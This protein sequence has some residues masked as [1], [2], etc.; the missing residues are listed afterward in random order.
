MNTATSPTELVSAHGDVPTKALWVFFVAQIGFGAIASATT[1]AVALVPILSFI[2]FAAVLMPRV[3]IWLL[4]VS[5]FLRVDIPGLVGVYPGDIVALLL[6][7]GLAMHV[8]THGFRR[9]SE[10]P[11][12]A[13][14]TAMMV[15]FAISLLA[16]FDPALGLKNWFRHLQMTFVILAASLVLD[17]TD[18]R[19]VLMLVLWLS[20]ALS[21]PNIIEAI[22]LGSSQRV[23][24]ISSLF[25]PFYLATAIIYCTIAYLLSESRWKRIL[26]LIAAI[27]LG[28]GIIATQT[29]EAMLHTV[30]GVSLSCWLVWKW[31]TKMHLPSI[32]RRVLAVVVLCSVAALIFL[33]G[34]IATF[35]T[36]AN[37][38]IQAVEGRSNTIFIR[39][40][41]WRTGINVFMDSPVLGIG[42]GQN[43]EWDKFLP[44]WRFDPMAQVSR[45]LGVHNDLITYAA[46][47]GIL[48]LGALFWFFIVVTKVGWKAYVSTMDKAHLQMLLAVWIPCLAVFARFFYGTHTFYSLGGLFNCLYFGMLIACLREVN[49]PA[50]EQSQLV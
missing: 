28:L 27:I 38:V 43:S 22:R 31:S 7:L 14:L 48:G 40:F 20:V 4:A 50:A 10:V 44:L 46:E 2:G 11:L 26:L 9:L 34:S 41:L 33:F 49:R 15:I 36:P 18:I 19:R 12:L 16:A 5:V 17:R 24:G 47:T 13:P 23:F 8:L 3:G 32:N 35:K 1:W 42:I 30:I 29:R 25:F 45:G 6:I 21:I 39:L 37:R